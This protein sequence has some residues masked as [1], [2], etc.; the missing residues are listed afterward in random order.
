[1]SSFHLHNYSSVA[2]T[3]VQTVQYSC[4]L[5]MPP[6]VTIAEKKRNSWMLP[7]DLLWSCHHF[8]SLQGGKLLSKCSHF[9]RILHLFGGGGA[10]IKFKRGGQAKLG[11]SPKFLRL[12]F[13]T[14]SVFLYN[15]MDSISGQQGFD[16][17]GGGAPEIRVTDIQVLMH[18]H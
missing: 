1:M 18:H 10:S 14:I 11:I 15:A 2:D 4:S 12:F 13:V 7:T 3:T 8:S 16:K 17:M 6:K 5:N 9:Q